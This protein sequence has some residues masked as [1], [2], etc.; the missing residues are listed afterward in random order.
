MHGTETDPDWLTHR[1]ADSNPDRPKAM[2]WQEYHDR[3]LSDW[4]ALLAQ[5]PEED[6]VQEFLELHPAMIP[7]GSG[8]IGPGGH[9]NSEMGLVF[10]QPQLRGMDR[11][12]LPDF[13]WVTQSSSLATPI[14][15][16]IEKPS[17]RWFRR[18]ERPTAHFT[19]AHDQLAEWKAWFA[20]ERNVGTFRQRY[21]FGERYERRRFLPQYLLVYGRSH[22]FEL[23]G[24]HLNPDFL[25][26]KRDHMRRDDEHFMTFDSLRPRH[27]HS[28]SITATMTATGPAPFAFSPVYGTGPRT[29]ETA[30]ML[31]SPLDALGRS[32][33]M[34]DERRQYLAARWRFWAE[35]HEDDLR[36]R[37]RITYRSGLE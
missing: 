20:N 12:F 16:E 31:G 15:I 26:H 6:R 36:L 3:A 17:R 22:E 29:G 11:S 4:C 34:S 9:H 24:G 33:M 30:L 8:D 2:A 10:R 21:L 23:G 7:G 14:L 19:A 18:D 1:S 27:D 5:D 13:M 35:R 25:N 32:V 28:N 37:R